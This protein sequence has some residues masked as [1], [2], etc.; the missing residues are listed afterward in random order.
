MP[1]IEF[2]GEKKSGKIRKNK[3][4]I[5]HIPRIEFKMLTILPYTV[6][7]PLGIS[8]S[9]RLLLTI[10]SRAPAFPFAVSGCSDTSCM[11]SSY[12]LLNQPMVL[13]L[14]YAECFDRSGRLRI[15]RA[16]HRISGN[17]QFVQ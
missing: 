17:P 5:P 8:N 4:K 10:Y 9:V 15:R 6:K 13:G 11:L 14:R 7:C 2:K 16:G 3:R 1:F 12:L